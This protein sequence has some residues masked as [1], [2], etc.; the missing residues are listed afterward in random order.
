MPKNKRMEGKPADND[1]HLDVLAKVSNDKK[2]S[3][4]LGI[5]PDSLRVTIGCPSW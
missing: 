5:Y 4:Q 1:V 2:K 3:S